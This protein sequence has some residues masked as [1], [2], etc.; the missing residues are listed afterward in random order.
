VGLDPSSPSGFLVNGQ[1]K[2]QLMHQF[3][4]NVHICRRAIM[5][6]NIILKLDFSDPNYPTKSY[7]YT[8]IHDILLYDIQKE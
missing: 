3:A 2:I 7:D 6:K 4:L 5:K 1:D 8:E